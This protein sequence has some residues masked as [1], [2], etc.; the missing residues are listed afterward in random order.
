[1]QRASGKFAPLQAALQ[2]FQY[3]FSNC[4]S[5]HFFSQLAQLVI[6]AWQQWALTPV[7]NMKFE[8]RL[9]CRALPDLMKDMPLKKIRNFGGKLGA[10]LQALGCSTAGEVLALPPAALH[11]HFGDRAPWILYTVQGNSD[12]PV[13]VNTSSCQSQN[14]VS[15]S[16]T[17][18]LNR[19]LNRETSGDSKYAFL[20]CGDAWGLVTSV[21]C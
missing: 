6:S 4:T 19:K 5:S 3:Q 15:Y 13:Q 2:S 7:A 11:Q 8:G 1:M 9:H 10:E 17:S 16:E 21:C 20:L 18:S 14:V 12:E